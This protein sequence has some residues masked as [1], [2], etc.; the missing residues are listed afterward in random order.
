MRQAGSLYRGSNG[1]HYIIKLSVIDNLSVLEYKLVTH[2]GRTRDN[3][4]P[5]CFV[6]IML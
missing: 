1:K 4:T 3:T 2:E 6:S 5:V